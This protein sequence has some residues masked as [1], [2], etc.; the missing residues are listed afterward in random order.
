[1]GPV[2]TARA[3]LLLLPAP[4]LPPPAPLPLYL[5]FGA[6]RGESMA[7]DELAGGGAPPPVVEDPGPGPGANLRSLL[8][9]P[10]RG[11]SYRLIPPPAVAAVVCDNVQVLSSD[12][13]PD[14]ERV[15]ERVD[16]NSDQTTPS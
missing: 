5:G 10:A 14:V 6:K 16:K 3:L 8:P 7:V 1:M 12:S 13:A 4:A 11:E 2:G 15:C 9:V